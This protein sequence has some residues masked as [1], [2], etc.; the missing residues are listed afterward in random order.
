MFFGLCHVQHRRK[1]LGS[2][3][4][5]E[6]TAR[7][8]PRATLLQPAATWR[9]TGG[10]TLPQIVSRP[11]LIFSDLQICLLPGPEAQLISSINGI[12]LAQSYAFRTLPLP[13]PCLRPVPPLRHRSPPRPRPRPETH[14]TSDC[15]TS[16]SSS[17]A[18]RILHSI[19]IAAPVR[20]WRSAGARLETA[21]IPHVPKERRQ[22]SFVL[23]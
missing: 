12:L 3:T 2:E 13:L 8:V 16:H 15:W 17:A 11:R 6:W 5:A 23:P 7:G 22:H 18:N 14:H 4:A 20:S 1:S 19:A 21:H 9:A 10:A